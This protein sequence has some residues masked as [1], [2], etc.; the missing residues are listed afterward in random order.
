MSDARPF[1][2]PPRCR[3]S[4]GMYSQCGGTRFKRIKVA[5]AHRSES[6]YL[7]ECRTCGHEN[8]PYRTTLTK[9]RLA[10]CEDCREPFLWKSQPDRVHASHQATPMRCR[11]CGHEVQAYHYRKAAEKHD[12]KAVDARAQQ[13]RAVA[14]FKPP[15]SAA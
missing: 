4:T 9:M 3:A 5:D 10:L 7:Y 8:Q 13:R 15:E 14:R 11:A 6:G 2:P 1:G 12:Q